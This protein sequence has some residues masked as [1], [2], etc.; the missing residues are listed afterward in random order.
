MNLTP[1]DTSTLTQNAS[2]SAGSLAGVASNPMAQLVQMSQKPIRGV[3]AT[4]AF[5]Q[6]LAAALAEV[7][8]KIKISAGSDDG[9]SDDSSNSIV[10]DFSSSLMPLQL[11]LSL[12]SF[13]NMRT[14]MSLPSTSSK[15][16]AATPN[17]GGA[18]PG[19]SV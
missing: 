15:T 6:T 4:K 5:E 13:N 1:I 19:V 7:L 12:N 2:T 10:P 8:S 14:A 3:E 17:S 16:L 9:S 11:S 18:T